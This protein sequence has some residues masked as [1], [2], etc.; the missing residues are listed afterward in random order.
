MD[1]PRTGGS[2]RPTAPRRFT[3][4]RRTNSRLPAIVVGQR[5]SMTTWRPASR[6]CF[7]IGWCDVLG[8]GD[9]DQVDGPVEQFVD[10]VD[11]VRIR[12]ARVRRTP[13]MA[14]HDG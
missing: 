12:I 5:L 2:G 13:P 14:L 11:E 9:D 3:S 10:A 6:H 4:P 7:A 1:L 8:V